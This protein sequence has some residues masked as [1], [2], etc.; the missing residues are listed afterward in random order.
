VRDV[1]RRINY[2]INLYG[3]MTRYV[4][5]AEEETAEVR[6]EEQEGDDQEGYDSDDLSESTKSSSGM[7][8]LK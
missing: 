8:R 7:T 3:A 1:I 6:E 2:V 4:G 5:G